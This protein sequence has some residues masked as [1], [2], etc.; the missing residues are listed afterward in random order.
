MIQF[1][2]DRPGPQEK[3][4]CID[5]WAQFAIMCCIY[6]MYLLDL[7]ELMDT[8]LSSKFYIIITLYWK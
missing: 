6:I 5:F 7:I 8:Y 4:G 3:L 2:A 1:K